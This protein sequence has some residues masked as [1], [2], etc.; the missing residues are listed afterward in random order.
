MSF[1]YIF[2]IIFGVFG[3]SFFL[4]NIRLIFTG[5]EFRGSCASNNPMVKDKFGN[6]TVCG[7]GPSDICEN[8]DD[9]KKGGQMPNIGLT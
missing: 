3:I 8:P 6:C 5:N 9:V 4:I 1:L 2:L 7:K